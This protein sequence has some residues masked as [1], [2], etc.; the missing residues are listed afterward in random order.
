L[1]GAASDDEVR[2]LRRFFL[3]VRDFANDQTIRTEEQGLEKQTE[4]VENSN[5]H[6][7]RAVCAGLGGGPG[8]GV[9]FRNGTPSGCICIPVGGCGM[10][11]KSFALLS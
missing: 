6:R 7:V 5:D 10:T 4:N 11:G 3:P 2:R 8:E 1:T 9:R